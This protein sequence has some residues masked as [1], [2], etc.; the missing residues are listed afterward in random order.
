MSAYARRR[1]LLAGLVVFTLAFWVQPTGAFDAVASGTRAVAASVVSDAG[2]YHAL[3]GGSC[4]DILPAGGSC[5]FTLTNAGTT[6][7]VFSVTR[8]SD[9]RLLVASYAV[10]NATPVASGPST[11]PTE[12]AVGASTTLTATLAACSDC[13]GQTIEV[14]WT[15]QGHKANILSSQVTSYKMT[16]TYR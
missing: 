8:E 15:V 16:I 14:L 7:V 13:L 10:T 1:Q 2:A 5:T 11:T 4:P 6:P 12:I 9:P 3:T